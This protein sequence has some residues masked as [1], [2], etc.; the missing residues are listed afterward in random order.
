[1]YGQEPHGDR[2]LREG[3]QGARTD[4]SRWPRQGLGKR[5][6]QVTEHTGFWTEGVVVWSCHPCS[7][8]EQPNLGVGGSQR[9]TGG[10]GA[11]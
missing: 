1:M 3:W 9:E 10:R 2:G 11:S 8:E 5:H 7:A 4:E 6:P